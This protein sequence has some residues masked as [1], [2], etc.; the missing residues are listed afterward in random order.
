MKM[1]APQHGEVL[2]IPEVGIRAMQAL[3]WTL[4]E[5]QQAE[6]P[7]RTTRSRKQADKE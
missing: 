6:K 1:Q 4:L 5:P 2:D 3:G 7:K